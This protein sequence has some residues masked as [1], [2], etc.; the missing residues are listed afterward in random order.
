MLQGAEIDLRMKKLLILLL[1]AGC[2]KEDEKIDPVFCYQCEGFIVRQTSENSAEFDNYTQQWCVTETNI[3]AI[4]T[5][6]TFYKDGFYSKL[7]C[8][9]EK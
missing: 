5:A 8:K 2:S 7:T 3:K 4:E 9:R 1:L 6:N